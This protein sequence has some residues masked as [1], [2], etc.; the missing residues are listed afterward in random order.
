ML[1]LGAGAAGRVLGIPELFGLATA[2]VIVTLAALVRVRLTKAT[3]AVAALAI[4]PV[5]NAGELALSRTHDR[6]L[7]GR[8]GARDSCDPAFRRPAGP[9]LASAGENLRAATDPRRA[10]ACQ[11]RA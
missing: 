2:V 5:V 9:G 4:P 3:V 7:R 1:G 6:E 8:Q 10:S 11:L